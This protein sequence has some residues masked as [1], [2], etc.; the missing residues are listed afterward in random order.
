MPECFTLFAILF[1][2]YQPNIA[3]QTTRMLAKSTV[4]LLLFL[5]SLQ[6]YFFQSTEITVAKMSTDFSNWNSEIV[7]CPLSLISILSQKILLSF[8]KHYSSFILSFPGCLFTIL[9][10]F[11]GFFLHV[12]PPFF[13]SFYCEDLQ[14][15][16]FPSSLSVPSLWKNMS[17][18]RSSG[19][20]LF[21]N[22][23]L[24]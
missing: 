11:T 19:I 4:I 2:V 23:H 16:V 13:S 17:T 12:S 14:G 6:A 1:S 22:L 7:H 20:I 24:I 9:T 8:L 10:I 15:P 18:N 3:I 5:C 21:V